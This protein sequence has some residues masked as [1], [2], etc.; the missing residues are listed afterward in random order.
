[1]NVILLDNIENLGKIG[2]MVT[3]KAGYGR[4]FLLPKGKAALATQAN[5]VEFEAK[6]AGLEKA[7]AEAMAAANARADLVRDMEL[8]IAA[9][10][11]NEG[12]LFGSI[13]PIDI[14]AAFAKVGVEIGR[15]EIR[16]E[17]GPLHDLGDFKVG[18][19]L[20]PEVNIEVSLK[21][22]AE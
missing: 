22:V 18:V 14:A 10:A 16:L 6:R 8:V 9:N 20:H 12:K 13:G 15:G 4:N 11:G 21:V 17:D 3:V 5:L 19:H 7:A 2:D 1:M